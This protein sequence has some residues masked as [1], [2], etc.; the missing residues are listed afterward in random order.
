[1]H[2]LRIVFMQAYVYKARDEKGKLVKGITNADSELDLASRLNKQGFVLTFAKVTSQRAVRK[3]YLKTGRLSANELLQFTSQ[4][5]ISLDSGVNLLTSLEDL[6]DGAPTAKIKNII[7]SI[8]RNVESG[9]SFRDALADY[10]ESFPKL[11]VAIV[12][13]GENTG[14]LPLVLNDLTKLLEWQLELNAKIKEASIYP[15]ILFIVMIL[16]VGVL[17]TVVIP[18]FEPMFADLKLNLPLPTQIIMSTSRIIRKF[19]WIGILLI[20]AFITTFKFIGSNEKGQREI[21]KLKLK[22]P[23]A[24]NLLE[25][26]ILSRFC[27]TF[28]LALRSGVNVFTALGIASEVT[29][30]RYVESSIIKARDYVNVGEKISTSLKMA[31]NF[32]HLVIRMI[33][34]GEQT[35]TLSD[36]LEKVNQYYDKEV[37]ATIKRMFSIFEPMMIVIMGAVVGGIAISVFLPLMQVISKVGD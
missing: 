6:S 37:P 7:E 17:V 10:P 24:G 32:P 9:R 33:N 21:D 13:A 23:L 12:G 3:S 28:A 20:V 1:M 19:W 8:G 29:G 14:K 27:H 34:I 18:K 22:L 35:G 4:L 30:N 25:K 11:Y 15:L 31:G 16:V 26:I 5:A 36:S 2:A